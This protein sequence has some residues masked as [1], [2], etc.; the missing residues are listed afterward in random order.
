VQRALAQHLYSCENGITKKGKKNCNSIYPSL[1]QNSLWTEEWWDR[2]LQKRTLAY[3]SKAGGAVLGIDR[4]L[5]PS[6]LL[7]AL[8]GYVCTHFDKTWESIQGGRGRSGYGG[9]YLLWHSDHIYFEGNG[10]GSRF[11]YRTHAKGMEKKQITLRGWDVDA[12]AAFGAPIHFAAMTFIPSFGF[13]SLLIMP[14]TADSSDIGKRMQ[15]TQLALSAQTL[16]HFVEYGCL[17]P[18]ACL[19]WIEEV[20]PSWNRALLGAEAM[21]EVVFLSNWSFKLTY[22]GEFSSHFWDQSAFAGLSVRW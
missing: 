6:C 19:S 21:I 13:D 15:R 2:G 17:I 8:G 16:F 1:R 3:H 18:R 20:R 5:F 12:H 14:S 11:S 4:H 9:V 7:G 10:I 22:F